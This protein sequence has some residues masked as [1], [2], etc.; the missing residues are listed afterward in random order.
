MLDDLGYNNPFLFRDDV[1]NLDQ[2]FSHVSHMTLS[3]VIMYRK[4][5]VLSN[6]CSGA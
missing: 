3:F 1:A 2:N 6:V 4:Y 5:I